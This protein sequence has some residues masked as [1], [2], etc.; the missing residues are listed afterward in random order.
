MKNIINIILICLLLFPMAGYAQ[1][2]SEL[3]G[4][5]YDSGKNPIA[6]CTISILSPKDSSVM[7]GG[8]SNEQGFYKISGLSEGNYIA[9]YTHLQ[10]MTMYVNISST[11]K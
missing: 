3:S 10:Y 2:S 6:Y 1:K 7:T 4:Y 8:V 9:K 5:I 11:G